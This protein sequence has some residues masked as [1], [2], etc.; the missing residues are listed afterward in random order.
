MTRFPFL[1]SVALV[2]VLFS[3]CG[4]F[5]NELNT[6]PQPSSSTAINSTKT[7][8][9]STSPKI[10]VSPIPTE[11]TSSDI[12]KQKVSYEGQEFSYIGDSQR[13]YIS[14]NPLYEKQKDFSYI[15]SE[16]FSHSRDFSGYVLASKNFGILEMQTTNIFLK[17]LESVGRKVTYTCDGPLLKGKWAKC[18]TNGKDYLT[19][20]EFGGVC[21]LF[22]RGT[23]A[24]MSQGWNKI[25]IKKI[26]GKDFYFFT[27][28]DEDKN[29]VSREDQFTEG[30]SY[31][32]KATR[33]SQIAFLENILKDPE[34]QK[35]I[36]TAD[37]FVQ[38]FQ[39][40]E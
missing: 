24:G 5:Q 8:I 3:G 11:I 4:E 27:C 31:E 28:V 7:P 26:E 15:L 29:M 25:Y 23:G 1:A 37:D 13:I 10:S 6:S 21:G 2:F 40:S 22:Y 18:E 19:Q 16:K 14:D 20:Y 17:N 35:N 30:D 36:K 39:L 34:N 32:K 33:L 9:I 12:K 38:S